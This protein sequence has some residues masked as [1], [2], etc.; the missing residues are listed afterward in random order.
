MKIQNN[1]SIHESYL[2]CLQLV[3]ANITD[4]VNGVIFL[5]TQADVARRRYLCQMLLGD[6]IF[7]YFKDVGRI[8][9]SYVLV[10]HFPLH[11][12]SN[13]SLRR[14]HFALWTM[15]FGGAEVTA[16]TLA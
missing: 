7:A 9:T 1:L 15:G 3:R 2:L 16:L 11:Y 8:Y 14:S 5:H 13:R 12:R 10:L 4:V 6:D